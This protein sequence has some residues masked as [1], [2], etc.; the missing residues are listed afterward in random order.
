MSRPP[1]RSRETFMTTSISHDDRG[2]R[3]R[4]RAALGVVVAAALTTFGVAVPLQAATAEAKTTVHG[5]VKA[6]SKALAD[7]PVGFWSRTGKKLT[8]TRT[9]KSGTFT[10]HV[11]SGVYGF[12]YVGT[13]PTSTTAVFTLGSKHYVR[14]L[15]GRSQASGTSY[16]I[17]QGHASATASGLAHGKPLHF[18]LQQAGRLTGQSAH[19]AGTGDD[20]GEVQVLRNDADTTYV[21][22][23]DSNPAGT[24]T[25][26]YLVPGTYRLYVLP[27]PPYLYY[28]TGTVTVVA[29]RT[30]TISFG[31]TVKAMV[32]GATIRGHVSS[33]ASGPAALVPIDLLKN[34]V[35]VAGARTDANGDFSIP[36]IEAGT[37]SLRFAV[38]PPDD[39]DDI[40]DAG[41]TPPTSDDYLPTTV[42]NVVVDAHRDDVARDIT[43]DT[44]GHVAGT[45]SAPG[46]VVVETD[47]H[48]IVRYGSTETPAFDLGGLIP[49]THY[50]V[51]TRAGADAQTTYRSAD[52]TATSG[53]VT[54]SDYVAHPTLTLSGT[55]AGAT[56][57]FVRAA[58]ALIHVGS[59]A[60]IGKTGHYSMAG[61]LPAQY[62]VVASATG[63]RDGRAA[64]VTLTTDTTQAL[65]VGVKGATYRARFDSGSA[66][67]SQVELE[68]RTAAGDNFSINQISNPSFTELPNA[69]GLAAGTYHYVK[70]TPGV[71]AA[72]GPWWFGPISGSVKLKAGSTTNVGTIALHVHGK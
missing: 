51:F 38:N 53:S 48:T 39:P 29:G 16:R 23:D 6:G 47:D 64:V 33:A 4:R 28:K 3:S 14:G 11:P 62:D 35:Q 68:A 25:T 41:P 45:L 70:Q 22:D 56:G 54:P 66:L 21:T 65:A 52:F 1:D 42:A 40:P 61:L 10:L 63:R 57:G 19:L 31:T 26:K 8:S 44:A 30:K 50:T 12:A 58:G 32:H 7:V 18:H 24:F 36:A 71:P 59:G 67:V 46:T 5:T 34:G 43:L 55:A 13:L 72:D 17:Y 37:Y 69:G 27:R 49:G 9:S 2:R 20:V 15:I 60:T